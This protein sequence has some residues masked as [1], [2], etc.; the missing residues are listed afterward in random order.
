VLFVLYI[1]CTLAIRHPNEGHSNDRNMLLS[2]NNMWLNILTRVNEYLLVYRSSKQ[3]YS[4]YCRQ[5]GS[6]AVGCCEHG[7]EH[8]GFIKA[9]LRAVSFSNRT[10]LAAADCS[11]RHCSNTVNEF[12]GA[13]CWTHCN[14]SRGRAIPT[15]TLYH[16]LRAS[17]SGVAKQ[18]FCLFLLH[19]QPFTRL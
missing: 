9:N 11:Y 7:D 16:F 18:L 12:P 3:Q 2:S 6:E 8:S 17:R 15:D 14:F 4:G 13:P 10:R 5:T 1:D 19:N